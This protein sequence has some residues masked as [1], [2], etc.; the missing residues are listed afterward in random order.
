MADE[1]EVAGVRLSGPHPQGPPDPVTGVA[2]D[3]IDVTVTV[4]NTTDHALHVISDVRRIL[5]DDASDTLTLRL[6]EEQTPRAPQ[7]AFP[8]E[9]RELG[10]GESV[11]LTLA[12]PADLKRI[13][14]ATPNG[15]AVERHD[16]R[17]TRQVVVSVAHAPEAFHLDTA[18]DPVALRRRLATWGGRTE[19]ALRPTRDDRAGQ[20][21]KEDD[22]AIPR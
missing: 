11:E 4:R 20:R 7:H 6:D 18:D 8:P 17:R 16:L 13:T 2:P 12:V 5:Y 9:F 22:D 15:V 1:L 21:G 3:F 14:G 10:P 19:V